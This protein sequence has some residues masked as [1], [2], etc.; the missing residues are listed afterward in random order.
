MK[1]KY[2]VFMNKTGNPLG[3]GVRYTIE[4]DSEYDAIQ[5]AQ[6]QHPHDKVASIKEKK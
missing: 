2:E 6:S 4:A 1:K 3:S 5:K